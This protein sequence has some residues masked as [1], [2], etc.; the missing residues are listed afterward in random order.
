MLLH[1]TCGWPD[2][3]IWVHL[4]SFPVFAPIGPHGPQFL[5]P[6]YVSYGPQSVCFPNMFPSPYGPQFLCSPN[7]FSSPVFPNMPKEK[8]TTHSNDTWGSFGK[9]APVFLSHFPKLYLCS[10][11]HCSCRMLNCPL[12]SIFFLFRLRNLYF[13]WMDLGRY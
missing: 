4:A 3:E 1:W 12:M 13:S 9:I 5:S 2:K 11:K 8:L 7:M 10:L 6:K